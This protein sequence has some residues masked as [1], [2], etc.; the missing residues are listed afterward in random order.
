VVSTKKKERV[1]KDCLIDIAD[2]FEKKYEGLD[3]LYSLLLDK[4]IDEVEKHRLMN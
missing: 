3:A 1:I 2:F 4:I